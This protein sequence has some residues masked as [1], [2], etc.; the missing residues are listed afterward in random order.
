[1][2]DPDGARDRGNE[3]MYRKWEWREENRGR[4]REKTKIGRKDG[5][6]NGGRERQL[7]NWR[8]GE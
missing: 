6:E 7:V 2:D 8:M 4:E 5:E 3:G 1:M